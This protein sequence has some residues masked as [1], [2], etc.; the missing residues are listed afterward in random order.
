MPPSPWMGSTRKPTVFGP[1]ARSSA[2][3]SPY[4]TSRKP[5]V[6]GPKPSRY[7]GSSENETMVTV[8]PWKLPRQ[9]MISAWPSG[10]PLIL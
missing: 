5:G 10:T 2:A 6:N 7:C 4:G 3:R 9:Q 1:M 8:R